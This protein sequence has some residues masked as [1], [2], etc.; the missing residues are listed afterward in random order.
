MSDDG[1]GL[2]LRKGD[3][4]IE[5]MTLSQV[6][7]MLAA[8]MVE[9]TD[10]V[11]EGRGPWIA[12][13]EFLAWKEEEAAETAKPEPDPPAAET[14]PP[15]PPK[16]TKPA[17]DEYVPLADEDDDEQSRK[18]A[19][20]KSDVVIRIP[21]EPKPQAPAPNAARKRSN[22]QMRAAKKKPSNANMRARQSQKPASGQP[23]A[24]APKSGASQS[25]TG[26]GTKRAKSNPAI[27]KPKSN[28]GVR[29]PK[30]NP[31]VRKPKSNP[32]IRKRTNKDS[33]GNFP[34]APS[35][36]TNA[37]IA[38]ESD[39][40]SVLRAMSEW[41]QKAPPMKQAAKGKR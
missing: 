2:S 4:V 16:E 5:S 30:S 20:P 39:L 36:G 13:P 1:P 17:E 21:D 3:K 12:I 28:A 26:G 38:D 31:G 9:E 23:A 37:A 6:K 22:P 32:G 14:P 41:E 33:E 15:A 34:A 40:E 19:K 11:R 7:D 18:P 25:T 24:A 35:A 8:G 29:K 10:C 27:R